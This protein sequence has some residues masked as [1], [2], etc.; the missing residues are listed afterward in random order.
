MKGREQGVER[1]TRRAGWR[2][3]RV[4]ISEMEQKEREKEN[5]IG[6]QLKGN[7]NTSISGFSS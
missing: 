3:E 6:R 7:G 4:N 2:T 1:E 5:E